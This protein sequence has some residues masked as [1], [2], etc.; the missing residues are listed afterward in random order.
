MCGTVVLALAVAGCG[1]IRNTI[2]PRPR[3]A[4]QLTVELAGPPSAAD[5]G[6]YA[7][8]A[9]GYF[10]QTDIN[11]SFQTPGNGQD[12]LTMLQDAQVDVAISSEP[13][14][15]LARNQ[16]E[17]LVSVGALVQRPLS[18]IPITIPAGQL[19]SG[20]ASLSTPTTTTTATTTTTG[21]TST[22][23]TKT[24]SSTGTTT[25]TTTPGTTTPSGTAT[26]T[27]GT[28]TS[29]SIT[30]TPTPAQVPTASLWPAKLV[31]LLGQSDAP[32]YNGLVVVVRKRTII[33]FS[34]LIR[35]FV[36]A[37]ARGYE[38]TRSDPAGAVA[39]LIAADPGLATQRRALQRTVTEMLPDFFPSGKVWGFQF[40]TQWNSFGTW[41]HDNGL[42]SNP[43]AIIAASTNELLAG[44]GV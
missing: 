2:T 25:T 33:N 18:Q 21:T 22:T 29:T 34:G 9:L 44:Q 24:G 10:K 40:V 20:G 30:T 3:S 28:K 27:K 41:L 43:N 42:V 14:V 17:A 16:N 35:R 37:A 4:N 36:Q 11:V 19:P 7:A 38:A 13:S 6:L 15:L 26:K 8:L 5:V 12:P 32:T 39:D 1:E 23:T 31:Q